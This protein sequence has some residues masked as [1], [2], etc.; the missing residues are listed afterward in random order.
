MKTLCLRASAVPAFHRTFKYWKGNFTTEELRRGENDIRYCKKKAIISN[1]N[2]RFSQADIKPPWET[3][4]QKSR[5]VIVT[6][7]ENVGNS[8]LEFFPRRLQKLIF[9][10]IHISISEKNKSLVGI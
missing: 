10:V 3:K 9:G 2:D 6:D 5:F 7:V 4:L 8:K 1:L